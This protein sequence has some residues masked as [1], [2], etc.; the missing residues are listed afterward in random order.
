MKIKGG[1]EKKIAEKS[2]VAGLKDI[3]ENQV[4]K[5]LGRLIAPNFLRFS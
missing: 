4:L 1:G 2:P 3:E 5:K